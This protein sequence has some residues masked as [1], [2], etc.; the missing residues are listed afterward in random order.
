MLPTN[1]TLEA[2]RQKFNEK[3]MSPK[4]AFEC[5][6]EISEKRIFFCFVLLAEVNN[7][8]RVCRRS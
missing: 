4:V 5:Q 3:S 7:E 1:D 6:M 2:G 8:L